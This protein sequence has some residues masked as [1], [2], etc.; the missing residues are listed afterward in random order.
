MPKANVDMLML[1]PEVVMA[2]KEGLFNIY[3]VVHI[4]EV[5]T[6]LT[7]LNAGVRNKAGNFPK[8]SVNYL[9]EM[10]LLS[11]SQTRLKSKKRFK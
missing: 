3:A 1:R 7:G 10:Q 2:A 5:M 11:Y 4:D 6:I 9:V 8:G